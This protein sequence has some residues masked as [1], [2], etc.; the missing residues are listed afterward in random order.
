LPPVT[1]DQVTSDLALG[2]VSRSD[3]EIE[4]LLA[5]GSAFARPVE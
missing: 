5:T 3:V 2:E 4:A 1:I